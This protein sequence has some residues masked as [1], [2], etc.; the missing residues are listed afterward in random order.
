MTTFYTD[1]PIW[2]PCL[3]TFGFCAGSAVAAG[4]T[5]GDADMMAV[6]NLHKMSELTIM[7]TY[8]K[9][10]YLK[11]CQKGNPCGT[12]SFY[13]K[14]EKVEP[15]AVEMLVRRDDT[16]NP[17]CCLVCYNGYFQ[18]AVDVCQCS[19]PCLIPCCLPQPITT[20]ERLET[21][22]N[23]SDFF[24]HELDH[25]SH[26]CCFSM[27]FSCCKQA[28]IKRSSYLHM[29]NLLEQFE[30][31]SYGGLYHFD[32]PDLSE[33]SIEEF[34]NKSK[35]EFKTTLAK[36]ANIS[37][38][39]VEKYI[40]SSEKQAYGDFVSSH[41]TADFI[42]QTGV[43]QFT[44]DYLAGL[45][46][47]VIGRGE[48]VKISDVLNT[49]T[50]NI[51]VN[52]IIGR[53]KTNES[54]QEKV[55]KLIRENEGGKPVYDVLGFQ[56]FFRSNI[57]KVFRQVNTAA[58]NMVEDRAWC[59][60]VTTSHKMK[61]DTSWIDFKAIVQ[62]NVPGNPAIEVQFVPSTNFISDEKMKGH[63]MHK[64]A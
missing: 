32:I 27:C 14:N 37:N 3:P 29:L 58:R 40:I 7:G 33:T 59:K 57:M 64:N 53:I 18:K 11:S 21:I 45:Q 47:S 23:V 1:L 17:T 28:D 55:D 19:I 61:M 2:P 16:R 42:K 52:G 44:K 62:L 13:W 39:L 6:S 36:A 20:K 30:A 5:P 38:M 60:A 25:T 51:E 24:K 56:V 4:W 46:R 10:S 54:L 48:K 63:D 9:T 41:L 50:N 15:E 49:L 22:K 43:A 8:F 34:N 26:S 35:E 31:V 12:G